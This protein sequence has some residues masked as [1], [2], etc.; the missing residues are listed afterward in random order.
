MEKRDNGVLSEDMKAL[1]E[2]FEELPPA[3][4]DE[5]KKVFS[6]LNELITSL[7]KLS[8]TVDAMKQDEQT[9]K[10]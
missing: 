6:A 7:D 9:M 1:R 4:G 5:Q 2:M 10:E 3:K 8:Q